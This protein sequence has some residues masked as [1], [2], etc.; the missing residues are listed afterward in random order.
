[1]ERL[2]RVL[3]G[4][5]GVACGDALGATLEFIS[6][7]IGEKLY[8]FHKDIIGGGVMNL[9]PGEVT[10]DTVMSIAVAEGI[11]E[12]SVS[13][14]E[15]I[16][17]RF[18]KWY[19]SNPLDIGITCRQAIEAYIRLR[20][21]NR[22]GFYVYNATRGMNAGNGSL[23][24][25][26][27]AALYYKDFQKMLDVTKDQSDMTHF[28]ER[29]LEACCL[30]NTL[31]YKY[32]DG[33]EKYQTLREVLKRK[34]LY[35][36]VFTMEREQLN[37]SGYVVDSMTCALWCFINFDNPEEI[38]CQAVNLYGDPDTI[39]AIAGGLAGVYYGCSSIPEGWR[40]KIL[41]KD[42]LLEIGHLM[43]CNK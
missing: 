23:M 37:P 22:A 29:T 19:K 8:G 42:K 30:Y 40:E 25:C 39:G 10:D 12:N 5:F 17:E 1:M 11:L 2:E 18:I 32:L 4:L 28:H 33:G 13:P 6:S 14:I 27:P 3:G 35:N 34:R 7:E 15:A 16:G 41:V 21:W 38:I 20:D 43:V 36:K 24:R 26:I 31:V 9:K